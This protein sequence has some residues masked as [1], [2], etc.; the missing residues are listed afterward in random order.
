M[1]ALQ[2]TQSSLLNISRKKTIRISERP[3]N[4]EF[5]GVESGSNVGVTMM[6]PLGS[7]DDHS[8]R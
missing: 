7:L 6:K 1:T 2:R 5:H 8:S 3:T 4:D